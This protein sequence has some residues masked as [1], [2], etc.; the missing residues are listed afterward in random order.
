MLSEFELS[1]L[2][3]LRDGYCQVS[4]PAVLKLSHSEDAK[5]LLLGLVHPQRRVVR[6]D[7]YTEIRY[8]VITWLDI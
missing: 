7:I 8:Y 5:L 6:G 4:V 3:A 2:R 1:W